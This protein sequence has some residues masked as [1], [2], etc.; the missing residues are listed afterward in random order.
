MVNKP[1]V[2]KRPSEQE[3]GTREDQKGSRKGRKGGEMK[4][5]PENVKNQNFEKE[6]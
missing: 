2:E 4:N 3:F 1:K 5:G 6:I